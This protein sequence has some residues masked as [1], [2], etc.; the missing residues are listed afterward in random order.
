M[1]RS[2]MRAGIDLGGTKI[3]AC[4]FDADLQPLD[5]RRVDTPQKSYDAL[6]DALA[7]QY[8]WLCATAGR[9]GL[10]L[11]I[12]VP[13]FVEETT[14]FAQTSNLPADNRP[15][16]RDL[17]RRLGI[18]VAFENDCR[19]FALSEAN[20]GA[21]AGHRTVVGLILGTGCGGGITRDGRLV[22]GVG[23][24]PIEIGHIG[25]PAGKIRGVSPPVELCKCGRYGCYETLVS[26]PGLSRLALRLSGRTLEPRRIV[27]SASEDAEMRQVLDVWTALVCEALRTLQLTIDPG[28][29]VL[30]GG[31]SRIPD[32]AGRLR[33]GAAAHLM[34]GVAPPHIAV[35]RFGDSS[36]VRGAAMLP[37]PGEP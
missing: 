10:P 23:R 12:G 15:L 25:I 28:C 3:E 26:G 32:L 16:Q 37:P 21:G 19:C 7:D 2:D 27:E 6:L 22:T 29:I 20:G 31:L 30:G 17:S 9:D 36:G 18:P 35:A 5:R 4:L 14:G 8:S 11:G 1:T 34:D 24:L 33:D 13:G